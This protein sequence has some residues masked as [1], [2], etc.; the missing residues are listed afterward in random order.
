M[1]AFE[2]NATETLYGGAAGGGK[3]YL[4]RLCAIAWAAAIPA[5]Q[6]YLFRR[7]RDDLAKNHVEGPSGLRALLAEWVTDR[8][9]EIV[10]DEVRF[11]NGARIYLCHCKDEKD[12]YK[13]QGAEMHV[14]LIDELTHF[15][16]TMYRFLRMRV[17]MV[18]IGVPDFYQGCFPRIL[19]GANPGNIG[20]QW[21]K[22]TF[23][24]GRAPLAIER[25]PEGE[26]EML[27]QFIQARLEDNPS[28]MADDPG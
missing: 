21:V 3:S 28:M 10:E 12:M 23:I 14:L 1:L 6:V 7:H 22:A 24:D 13:Y 25:T 19:C 11:E 16:E 18:G 4:I 26:G 27:R 5:L 8:R 2:S 20:H 15:T 17:R 9:C